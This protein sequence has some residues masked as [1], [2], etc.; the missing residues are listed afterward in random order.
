MGGGGVSQSTAQKQ[1]LFTQNLLSPSPDISTPISAHEQTETKG[2]TYL[3][4]VTQLDMAETKLEFPPHSLHNA[5]LE[6]NQ[7]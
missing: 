5:T 7:V 1:V 2:L 6:A 3:S 4:K